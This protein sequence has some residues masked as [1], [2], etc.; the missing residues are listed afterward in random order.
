M[1]RDGVGDYLRRLQAELTARGATVPL[2]GL[3]DREVGAPTEEPGPTLRLPSAWPLRQRVGHARRWLQPFQAEILSLHVVPYA[4]HP[5][6]LAFN[7]AREVRSL[8]EDYR[9]HL[10]FHELW[11]GE[12]WDEP[13]RHRLVGQVQRAALR[14]LVARG[15][16]GAV[17]TTNPHYAARLYRMGVPAGVLPLAGNVPVGTAGLDQAQWAALTRAHPDLRAEQRAAW[18]IAVFFGAFHPVWPAEP[19]VPQLAALAIGE[20]RRLA[21][22]HVG[23]PGGGGDTHWDACAVRLRDH[24]TWVRLG[25]MDLEAVSRVMVEADAGVATTPWSIVGKSGT[26]ASMAEHGLPVLVNRTEAGDES[27][28]APGPAY[29]RWSTPAQWPVRQAPIPHAWSLVAEAWLSVLNGLGG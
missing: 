22:I 5:K 25:E 20:G 2:V 24:A 29:L 19:F 17:H 27:L 12:G 1:G 8:A 11:I 13:W 4:W 23:R 7:L 15:Q 14:Q 6:G 10:F 3:A 21:L 9:L 18:R 28:A 16:P 26:A